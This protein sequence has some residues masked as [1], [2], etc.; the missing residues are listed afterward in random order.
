MCNSS[1]DMGDSMLEMTWLGSHIVFCPFHAHHARG[2]HHSWIILALKLVLEINVSHIS[3]FN[4][5]SLSFSSSCNI[6]GTLYIRKACFGRHVGFI[7]PH[8]PRQ[9]SPLLVD[10]FA[11]K[12]YKLTL[13]L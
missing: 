1:E 9:W 10:H 6:S 3:P 4:N 12:P 7:L 5:I 2:H 8:G 13:D 11:I